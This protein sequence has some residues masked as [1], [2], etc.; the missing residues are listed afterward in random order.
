MEYKQV[1]RRCLID[2]LEIVDRGD[3]TLIVL[4]CLTEQGKQLSLYIKPHPEKR[5]WHGNQ[6]R[7]I[8]Q[9]LAAY[10][11]PCERKERHH[12]GMSPLYAQLLGKS[13]AFRLNV[14]PLKMT[15]HSTGETER[16][17]RIDIV[18]FKRCD[19]DDTRDEAAAVAAVFELFG[20]TS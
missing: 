5:G 3:Y 2:D 14:F 10:G 9:M 18:K 8:R 6:F 7:L 4:N 13:F 11:F 17:R 1:T 20:V 12:F 15:K 16:T 19:F